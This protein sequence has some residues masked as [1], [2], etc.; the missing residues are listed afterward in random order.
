MFDYVAIICII[1][2]SIIIISIGTIVVVEACPL[3]YVGI[4]NTN[5]PQGAGYIRDHGGRRVCTCSVLWANI[6]C[7]QLSL[8][9]LVVRCKEVLFQLP[10]FDLGPFEP[11]KMNHPVMVELSRTT[12]SPPPTPGPRRSGGRSG[13]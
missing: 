8:L 2:S 1:C 10:E 12:S 6:R 9:V 13:S 5:L 4:W 11:D 3:A 7:N